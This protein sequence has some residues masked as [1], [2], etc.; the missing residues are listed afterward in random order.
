M[1]EIK[2]I[3][4]QDLYPHPDNPRKELGDLTELA[5]SIRIS[6]VLQNLTVVPRTRDM[7]DEE[8]CT[9]CEEYRRN[10]SEESQRTVNKHCVVDGYTIIIGHRRHAA[11]KLAGVAELPCIVVEM[12]ERDQLQTMLVENMQRSDLTVY[13]QAQ[14][15][16]MMLDMGN[17]VD[18]I[19]EKSGFSKST[20]RRRL[21]MAELDADTLKEVSSRQ[22][23]LSD[24]DKL[25]QVEN[26]KTR[27][28]LL[29]DIGTFN[30]DG[31]VTRAIREEHRKKVIPEAKKLIAA[32]GLKAVPESDRYSGKYEQ[33]KTVNLDNWKPESGF[34][35]NDA[36]G[37]LYHLDNW[38]SLYFYRKKK[39]APAEKKSKE[40][41]AKEK[42]I[43]DAH[44]AIKEEEAIAFD[45]R[46]KFVQGLT[47]TQKNVGLFLRGAVIGAVASTA[48]YKSADRSAILRLM[49][50]D[51]DGKWNEV[52]SG[53]VN[54]AISIDNDSLTP[55]IIYA[56][57]QDSKTNGYHTGY[58]G[59]WP[60]YDENLMLDALYAWLTLMGY[61]MSDD[62]KALQ[63]GTHNLF[64][65]AIEG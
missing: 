19:A 22:I 45:L 38:G 57:Y 50:V 65:E 44:A 62:E 5:D 14:G 11:A 8:Y 40:Q 32:L 3:A 60:K 55:A 21:K 56:Q 54:A 2:Y 20:I 39:K 13:E 47:V 18:T 42:A 30:F 16:Q 48:L 15:F 29:K 64:K 26:I 41:I 58:K 34:G 37:V 61:E 46:K 28:K 27:N 10:P 59:D 24:F 25:A 7:T 52:R 63:N 4:V 17:T 53:A 23:S 35:L 6:G 12:S 33:I 31:A 43:E 1:A 51:P 36:D 49:G 9:A